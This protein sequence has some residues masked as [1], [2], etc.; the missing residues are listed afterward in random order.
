M[1]RLLYAIAVILCLMLANKAWVL[2]QTWV[3]LEDD[4]AAYAYGAPPDKAKVTIIAFMNY[5]SR[6]S[7]DVNAAIMTVVEDQPDTRII[8][9][10]SSTSSAMA[11]RNAQIAVAAALQ[12]NFIGMH[13]ELMRNEKPLTDSNIREMAERLKLDPDKLLRDIQS[14]E[15]ADRLQSEAETMRTMHIKATPQFIF[16]HELLYGPDSVDAV[17]GDFF[18]LIKKARG[19]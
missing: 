6:P 17:A 10:I 2:H 15:V 12:K 3:Y 1:T 14:P 4:S 5:A 11:Y 16:N 19:S 7:K 9:H 8:F 13:E 18:T